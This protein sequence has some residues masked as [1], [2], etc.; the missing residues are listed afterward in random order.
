MLDLIW[1]RIQA[2]PPD[3]ARQP[4]RL[5]EIGWSFAKPGRLVLHGHIILM[6][7]W[8]VLRETG[9]RGVRCTLNQVQECIQKCGV[10][11]ESPRDLICNLVDTAAPELCLMANQFAQRPS[12]ERVAPDD[13]PAELY[14]EGLLDPP[15]KPGFRSPAWINEFLEKTNINLVIHEP[16]DYLRIGTSP[17]KRLVLGLQ[18]PLLMGFLW[19]VLTHVGDSFSYVEAARWL[20]FAK[21][22][23][24][25][26]DARI[27]QYRMGLNRLLSPDLADRI[28]A[29]AANK[30][31]YIAGSGWSFVWI[32]RLADPKFSRLLP[33]FSSLG[34]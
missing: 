23:S 7:V 4:Q 3:E 16:E 25:P 17:A 12:G 9:A 22:E 18:S 32:R 26:R 1:K 8:T 13:L 19:L 15:V 27:Y 34:Q 31:Y 28:F 2:L 29:A 14:I 30:C 24:E 11:L 33:D 5:Q 6:I 21:I 20:G 10:V